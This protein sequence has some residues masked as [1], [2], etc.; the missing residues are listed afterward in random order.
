MRRPRPPPP[1]A[2]RTRP[3]RPI[4][5]RRRLRS[6]PRGRHHAVDRPRELEEAG[7]SGARY[8]A[9]RTNRCPFTVSKMTGPSRNPRKAS[10]GTL[11]RGSL[12]IFRY[13]SVFAKVFST[14]GETD[15]VLRTEGSHV[16]RQGT[17]D[18]LPEDDA[19]TA[20]GGS[21]RTDGGTRHGAALD[22]G[23]HQTRRGRVDGCQGIL[24]R[25]PVREGGAGR[26]A[27]GVD[28]DRAG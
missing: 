10:I 16:R 18:W 21:D 3:R 6:P 15:A 28:R 14:T 1:A 22:A 19:R 23:R 7:H 17:G 25:P 11:I 5:R 20:R 24:R 13:P 8:G 26:E 27:R 2:R 9:T 4:A 12:N